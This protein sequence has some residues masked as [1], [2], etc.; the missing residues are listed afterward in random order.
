MDI[1]KLLM[2]GIVGGILYFLLGY[3]IYGMLLMDFM[4]NHPGTALN[5]DRAQEEMRFMYL[6]IGNLLSG[7]LIAYI[8][9]KSN[10]ST[11]ASGFITGG[12][13]GLLLSA[14]YDSTMYGVTNIMSKTAIAADVAAGTVMTAIV[15]AVVG[16]VLGMGKKAA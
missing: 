6:I 14:G 7:F 13:I 9:I 16:V 3:L 12:I 10:V 11:A 8:F 5:V 2:G 1:K 15:G 4:K